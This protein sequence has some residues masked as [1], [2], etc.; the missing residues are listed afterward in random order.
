LFDIPHPY[1]WTESSCLTLGS[2]Y[3]HASCNAPKIAR[4]CVT[5]PFA[6]DIT[7]NIPG[8]LIVHSFANMLG[9]HMCADKR[10]NAAV[11]LLVKAPMLS[12]PQAMRAA[13]FTDEE[14]KN[15]TMQMQVCR[16]LERKKG[17]T[18]NDGN[19][20][21]TPLVGGDTPVTTILS[22]TL[23]SSGGREVLFP[24]PKLKRRRRT[25]SVMQQERINKVKKDRHYKEAL[26][27]ATLEYYEECKKIGNDERE[28]ELAA[29]LKDKKAR[30]QKIA[31]QQNALAILALKS[32]ESQTALNFATL[33][34][35]E[36][37]ILIHYH[38]A[39]PNGGKQEKMAKWKAIC[40]KG[41]KPAVCL[42]W[43]EQE[44]ATLHKLQTEEITMADT[45]LG[46]QEETMKREL[47]ITGANM[48][49]EEWSAFCIL[50]QKK[51]D[52]RNQ[53]PT[54]AGSGSTGEELEEG[55]AQ[56]KPFIFAQS[57]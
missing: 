42:P 11:D 6:C 49:D 21:L 51:V 20:F 38:S 39:V 41:K 57:R 32:L 50:R 37:D 24:K 12:V 34:V 9:T 3:T 8:Q 25:S 10:I 44:E 4:K 52:D 53:P 36:L 47:L 55:S 45:H 1:A 40:D 18:T 28:L 13:N 14:S 26:K 17:D 23:T 35:A 46:R 54:T 2:S 7:H 5:E 33:M 19:P 27:K 43:T 15:R 29:L 22:L 56:N 16:A 30:I 31:V 48:T